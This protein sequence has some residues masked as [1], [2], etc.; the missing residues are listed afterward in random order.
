MSTHV[1][2]EFRKMRK[3]SGIALLTLPFPRPGM[4]SPSTPTIAAAAA[5]N[6]E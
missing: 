2:S 1:P 6:A 3:M 4:P 5:S